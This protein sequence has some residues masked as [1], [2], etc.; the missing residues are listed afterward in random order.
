MAHIEL[1]PAPQITPIVLPKEGNIANVN[2]SLYPLP[3]EIYADD[4]EFKQACV[5]EV[6]YIYYHLSGDQLD[7]E[8]NEG[9]VYAFYQDAAQE[10]NNIALM[11]Q[12][13]NVLSSALGTQRGKFDRYGNLVA[14]A[15]YVAPGSHMEL[16]YPRFDFG[17]S[18][19][20]SQAIGAEVEAAGDVTWY[21]TA[22]PLEADVQDYNLQTIIES[23]IADSEHELYNII[24]LTKG[25]NIKFKIRRVYFKSPRTMW[26]F[27]GFMMGG[28]NLLGN[29]TNYGMYNDDSTFDVVPAWSQK[30]MGQIFKDNITV[31]TSHYSFKVVN[32]FLRLYPV[33]DGIYPSYMWIEFT[34]PKD[35]W[36]DEGSESG[37]NG[38]NSFFSLPFENIP[39]DAIFPP[40]KT[41]MKKYALAL[42]M[43][44]LG[45]VRSK[46]QNIPFI[47]GN[48]TLNGDSLINQGKEQLK[49]LKETLAKDLEELSYNKLAENDKKLIEDAKAVMVFPQVFYVG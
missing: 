47:N 24:D 49:D 45:N 31:R 5:E 41:W 2:S 6:K 8:L 37:V 26:R 32:N 19:K 1:Q 18:Y 43:V 38:V 7:I 17:I 9:Q 4:D 27:Y 10:F 39:Y 29:L 33:P 34:L 22:I 40:G 28:L 36:A 23:Q 11:H 30:L 44:A 15:G 14:E 12:A 21:K 35:V 42:A 3:Y 13:K 48:I 20:I 25:G 16:K 46:V